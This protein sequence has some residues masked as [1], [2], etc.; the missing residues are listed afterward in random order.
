MNA[1]IILGIDPGSRF[2]G[3]GVI[4]S[5]GSTENHIDHGVISIPQNFPLP[6]KLHYLHTELEQVIKR[7][8]PSAFAL[9]NIFLGK[10]PKSAFILGHVRGSCLQLAFSHNLDILEFAP[11]EIKKTVTGNGNATKE[12]LQTV[13]CSLL[14]ISTNEKLDATD[15]LGIAITYSRRQQLSEFNKRALTL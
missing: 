7:Y 5:L 11:R 12:I 2:T 15:A 8:K 9:E 6:Q 10:N 1:N 3:F 14:S 4:S 13:V